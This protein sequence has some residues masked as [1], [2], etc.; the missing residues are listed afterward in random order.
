MGLL[1]GSGWFRNVVVFLFGRIAGAFLLQIS[2]AVSICLQPWFRNRAC[3]FLRVVLFGQRESFGGR[4][5][6]ARRAFGWLRD[7]SLN[8][9]PALAG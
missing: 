9:S 8:L 3:S 5:V 6:N 1:F 4:S 7:G 2:A